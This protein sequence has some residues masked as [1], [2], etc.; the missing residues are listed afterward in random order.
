MLNALIPI[1]LLS[2]LFTKMHR[3]QEYL[4]LYADCLYKTACFYK[5]FSSGKAPETQGSTK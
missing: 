3:D 5:D 1:V 2:L 4:K